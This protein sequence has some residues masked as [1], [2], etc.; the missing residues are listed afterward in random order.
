MSIAARP[1]RI[2]GEIMI[3]A[4]KLKIIDKTDENFQLCSW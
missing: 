1:S 4:F 3:I 2:H